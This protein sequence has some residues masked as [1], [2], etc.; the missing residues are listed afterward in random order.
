AGARPAWRGPPARTAGGGGAPPS[1][2]RRRALLRQRGYRLPYW[3]VAAE[4]INYR[5]FFD[6]NELA[7]VRVEV[8]AVFRDTHRFVLR[9]LAERKITGLRIDHPDG[10]WDPGAYFRELQRQYVPAL[11][12]HGLGLP[13]AEL[14]ALD[15]AT[16][17][18]WLERLRGQL[19]A[20]AAALL[21]RPLYVLAEKI[22]SRGEDLPA[23][24]PIDGTTGYEFA[25]AATGLFVD[26]ASAR[27]FDELYSG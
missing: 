4:E 22:L 11:L 2:A 17:E 24:W 26:P 8:P 23:A 15:E 3:G 27:A 9:L 12:E 18:S 14:S 5:R 21:Q 19:G 13:A 7:G 20:E 1:S 6:I 25:N 16:E 10:L